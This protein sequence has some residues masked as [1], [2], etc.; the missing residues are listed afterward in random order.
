MKNITILV[1]MSILFFSC[2]KE[3]ITYT[4]TGQFLP[5]SGNNNNTDFELYQ[6]KY[7][8]ISSK[9]LATTKT[10]SEGKFSFT[11]TTDN[12]RDKLILRTS[13]GFGYANYVTDI[14]VADIK[15]LIIGRPIYHLIVNLNVTKT[16]TNN[17]TLFLANYNNGNPNGT[18]KV[19]GPFVSGRKFIFP[20]LN[21]RTPT[22]DPSYSG[23]DHLYYCGFNTPYG[24]NGTFDKW[25]IVPLPNKCSGDSVYVS[26]DIK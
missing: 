17:D 11:Y 16:Y 22:S 12:T 2:R 20:N 24:S 10:D 15:D 23:T 26:L 9:V 19:A 3:K 21:V 8:N 6:A 5:C 13:S 7:D 4:L 25:Y 1:T 18:I 14:D